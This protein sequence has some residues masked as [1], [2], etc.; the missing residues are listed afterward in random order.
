MLIDIL[1]EIMHFCYNIFN[2]YG[3]GIITFT[4]LSK[5]ILLP[6]TIWVQKNSIKMVKLQP[7]INKIKT[8]YFK[9]KD[10]IAEEEGELYKKEKYNPL[11]SLIPLFVQIALLLGLISVINQPL[12]YIAK[13]DRNL[14]KEMNEITLKNN[15]SINKESSSIE[16][17][18]LDEIKNNKNIDSYKALKDKYPDIDK[19]IDKI[20]K[21]NVK[22]LGF[23]LTKIASKDKGRDLLP[24]CMVLFQPRTSV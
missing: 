8:K 14:I 22:F 15:L 19:E 13:T 2:S 17:N 11:A 6:I 21:L 5:I 23:D 18:T 3:L 10:R 7:E 4:L 1:G 16:V 12:K 24:P 20:Q 9:D